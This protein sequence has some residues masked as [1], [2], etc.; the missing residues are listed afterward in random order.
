M[1]IWNKKNYSKCCPP[2]PSQKEKNTVVITVPLYKIAVA[3]LLRFSFYETPNILKIFWIK[4][5]AYV[6]MYVALSF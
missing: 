3:V 4:K 2:P 5:I 1:H 6:L